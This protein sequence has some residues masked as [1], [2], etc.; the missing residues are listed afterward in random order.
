MTKKSANHKLK[1]SRQK[2]LAAISIVMLILFSMGIFLVEDLRALGM[3]FFV[4]IFITLVFNLSRERLV[5][6]LKMLRRNFFFMIFVWVCNL[7]FA[8][9][10]IATKVAIRLFVVILVVFDFSKILSPRNFAE[11]IG[12]LMVPLRVFKVDV[13][14][15]ILTIMVALNMV[16]ALTREATNTSR[17]LVLKGVDNKVSSFIKNPLIYVQCYFSSLMKRIREMERALILK[18]F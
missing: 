5:R 17:A 9:I 15:S 10:E 7:V 4:L 11:G 8:D 1:R 2:Y 6:C 12:V 18:G 16:P 3:I 13:E 14:G